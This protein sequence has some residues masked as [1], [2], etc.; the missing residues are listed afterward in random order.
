MRTAPWTDVGTPAK[1]VTLRLLH[2]M[3]PLRLLAPRT[4]LSGKQS[5]KAFK[6]HATRATSMDLP[7]AARSLR[8]CLH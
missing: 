1:R 3:V 7:A 4:A 8:P 5:A 6:M 2:A